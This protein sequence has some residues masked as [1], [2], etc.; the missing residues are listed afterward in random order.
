LLVAVF[1]VGLGFILLQG[2][3]FVLYLFAVG[4]FGA[5]F[6]IAGLFIVVM[7]IVARLVP[8]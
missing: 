3:A 2:A 8:P 6:V 1:I 4:L 7:E 5:V